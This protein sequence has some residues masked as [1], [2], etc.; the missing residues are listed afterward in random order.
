M[1]WALGVVDVVYARRGA[2]EARAEA[3]A[4]DGYDFIDPQLDDDVHALALPAGCP[5]SF[6]KPADTW[7]AT[8]APQAGDGMWERAV[9]WWSAAPHALLEPWAGGV[10]D[11]VESFHAFRAEVPGVR[12]LV[13]TGHVAD[14]GGDPLELLEFADHV[15]LRQG[16]RGHTQVHVDDGRGEVDFAAVLRRLEQLDYRGK[17]AVEYFDLAFMGWALDDPEAW[18]K[19]LA[20]FVR[21]LMH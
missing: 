20:A 7:C 19:D 10:V 17:L 21:T 5:T 11:S 14:W 2:I 15:Q 13:D 8:P 1:Q 3:A 6:P 12:L 9:R 18:A 16:C 4:H